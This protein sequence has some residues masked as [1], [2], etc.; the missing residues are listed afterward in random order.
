MFTFFNTAKKKTPHRVRG[1][2]NGRFR[3]L[4]LHYIRSGRTFGAIDDVEGHPSAFPQRLETIGLNCGMV[5]EYIL[6][7]I[8][9][10]KAKAL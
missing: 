10:N 5:H 3:F 7:T 8:L 1:L 9:F 6:A 4:L 2:Y